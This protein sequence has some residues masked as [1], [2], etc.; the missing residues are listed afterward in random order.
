MRESKVIEPP[1]SKESEMVVLG[2][3]LTS[4]KSLRIASESLDEGDFYFNEHKIIFQAIKAVYND[5]QVADVHLVC[6]ELKCK[7]K[8][9]AAGDII[10]LLNLVQY[11][12]TSAYIDEYCAAVE[13]KSKMR[14]YLDLAEKIQKQALAEST[15]IS[16]EVV[17]YVHDIE[18]RKSL[19][20]KFGIKFL[21]QREENYLL[22]TPPQKAMLLEYKNSLGKMI[23]FLPKGIVAM[24]VG[25]GGV[26]KSHL[27]AQL[28][29]A[30]AT[31]TTWLD[32]YAPTIQGNVFLGLGENQCDDI[33]RLLNKASKRIRESE[34]GDCLLTEASKRIA[35]FSFC[36]QQAAFI[37][38]KKP[39]RYFRDF[40]RGLSNAVPQGG[41]SLIVLDPV[42]R[43]LGADAE[44][45][46]AAA[47][48]FIALLEELS[49][50]LPGNP[51][52]LFAHHVN[53]TALQQEKQGQSAA[54]GSSAL[55][56]GV[57][58]QANLANKT[59]EV[60]I[61]TMTKSNFTQILD[62]INLKK[63]FDGF[64]ER[65]V[66]SVISNDIKKPKSAPSF[67]DEF[68]NN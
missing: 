27:L 56:D 4:P 64:I 22:S 16:N 50:D 55:T 68:T 21:N 31:G 25:A 37:E 65:S 28:A 7:G 5:C 39:S 18:K 19:N 49:M 48:Q 52:I 26:G 58:W 2:C 15:E 38:D 46:N 53:K 40:K 10:Y 41:W 36:G 33:H 6:A 67:A 51:T 1:H 60:S 47:T 17:T 57:R 63:D 42:S 23:G 29:I 35:P 32:S 61:L 11:V 12:G 66:D 8:L 13:K 3:M 43:L 44:T 20:Q 62:V 45:D 9:Q 34:Q 24:L 54:R 59:T 14:Q 30:I